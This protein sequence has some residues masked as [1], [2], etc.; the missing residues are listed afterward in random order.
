M[1]GSFLLLRRA[2]DRAA[3]LII[4]IRASEGVKDFL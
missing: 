1:I 2:E 3:Q 4:V